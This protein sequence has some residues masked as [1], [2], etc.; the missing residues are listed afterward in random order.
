MMIIKPG[1]TIQDCLD[2]QDRHGEFD[3]F[4]K[5]Y[6]KDIN[7]KERLI[8]GEIK[9]NHEIA[10]MLSI[11]F[12]GVTIQFWEARE[13]NYRQRLA[14]LNEFIGILDRRIAEQKAR[15]YY[16]HE[17]I[18]DELISIKKEICE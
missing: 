5:S 4:L 16:I 13:N 3:N 2:E 18:V 8:S 14:M 10:E 15:N 1:D 12:K 7:L 17:A 9:I 6:N 11:F